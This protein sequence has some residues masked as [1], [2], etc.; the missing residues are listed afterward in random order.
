[1]SNKSIIRIN[2][3]FEEFFLIGSIE[4][5]EEIIKGFK[6]LKTALDNKEVSYEQFEDTVYRIKEKYDV[7]VITKGYSIE[8]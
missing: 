3:V 6:A 8:L 1:M 5:I 7:E 4:T 2:T